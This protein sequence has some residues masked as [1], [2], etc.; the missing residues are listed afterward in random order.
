MHERPTHRPDLCRC[1]CRYRLQRIVGG[2]RHPAVLWRTWDATL[3]RGRRVR[4]TNC[5]TFANVGAVARAVGTHIAIYVDTLAPSPVDSATLS[6]LQQV[7]DSRLY[8]LD[9]ATFGNVSDIDGN[10]VVI[11]LMTGTVNHLTSKA[12]CAAAGGGYIAGFFF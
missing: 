2:T 7:F 11:E 8:P 6:A 9:T 4:V 5:S 1:L 10:S 12:D 3:A